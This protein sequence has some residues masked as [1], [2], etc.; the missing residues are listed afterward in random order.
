M[1]DPLLRL[2]RY[3]LTDQFADY[4]SKIHAC[5]RSQKRFTYDALIVVGDDSPATWE[6]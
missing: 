5:L 3:A 4:I 2:G 1:F 6:L